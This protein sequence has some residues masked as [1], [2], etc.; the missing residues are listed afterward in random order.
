MIKDKASIIITYYNL[1][2]LIE[3]TLTSAINQS[4]KNTEIILVNDGSTDEYSINKLKELKKKYKDIVLFIDQKNKGAAVARNTGVKKSQGKYICCLDSDDKLHPDYISQCIKLLKTNN[5][6]KIGFVTTWAQLFGETKEIWRTGNITKNELL[7][8]NEI[9]ISSLFYKKIWKE[10]DGYSENL[11]GYED[12]DF[13]I[14]IISKGY[15]WLTIKKPLFY[16]RKRVGSKLKTS[17]KNKKYL[18][19]TIIRNNSE[20]YF[21]KCINLLQLWKDKYS[22]LYN[23]YRTYLKNTDCEIK[24]YKKEINKLNNELTNIHNSKLWKSYLIYRKLRHINN[25]NVAYKFVYQ[26]GLFN[27]NKVLGICHINWHGVKN[28]TLNQCSDVI[29]VENLEDAKTF[30]F[31]C[32]FINKNK[33]EKISIN[34]IPDGTN[35]FIKRIK[36][37][38]KNIKIFFVW[39]G[40]FT[41]QTIED[42]IYRFDKLYPS[43]KHIY[44]LGFVKD[45]MDTVFTK[46]GYNASFIPNIIHQNS[47]RITI[48]K[49]NKLDIGVLSLYLW[50]KNNMN[51]VVSASMV[52]N[53]N[54]HVLDF[55]NVKYLKKLFDNKIIRHGFLPNNKFIDLLSSMD[56]N[57]Y[58]SLTECYPMV[59]I[60]SMQLGV[61]CLVGKTSENLL[62][63]YQNLKK[64][65]VVQNPE[66]IMEIKYKIEKVINNKELLLNDIAS[67]SESLHTVNRRKILEFFENK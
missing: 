61:P 31:I 15:S 16:Y 7:I 58:I 20:I 33:I 37:I 24:N 14:K 49:N 2:E 4:Y 34:A 23:E 25:N 29:L 26:E 21:N 55:P 39:H 53:A 22:S 32:E 1:G 6:K 9:H 28:A 12:W 48:P 54:I 43:F 38:F 51:Q 27:K 64:Y 18:I 36:K 47:K 67:F 35:E 62:S 65:L 3:E 17:D 60:E 57:L 19:E 10:V 44:K 13:W 5:K 40:S 45:Q 59:F 52:N 42:H 41:Q 66:D 46:M 63:D 30:E 11:R 8:Q 50:H 56:I